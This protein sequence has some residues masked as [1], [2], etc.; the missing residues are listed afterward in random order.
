MSSAQRHTPGPLL[1]LYDHHS[2]DSARP[3]NW[4]KVAEDANFDEDG[5]PNLMEF[6]QNTD[7]TDP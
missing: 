7:P 4:D 5:I 3:F 6:A 1:N 2:H